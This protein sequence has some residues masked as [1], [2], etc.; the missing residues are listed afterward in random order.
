MKPLVAI[1][2]LQLVGIAHASGQFANVPADARNGALGGMHAPDTAIRRV[3]IGYRQGYGMAD[4]ATR[5]VAATWNLGSRGRMATEY[6]HF[7]DRIY[8]EQQA[9]AGYSMRLTDWLTAGIR[10]RYLRMATDDAHYEARQWLAAE[11][12]V[13]A[14][15]G[16]RLTLYA[17]GGSRP[18]DETRPWQ[19]RIG[20]AYR[21]VEGLTTLVDL[22]SEERTRLRMGAE[23]C[24]RRHYFIRAGL[25]THPTL[26]TFGLGARLGI[27][28]I[29]FAVESHEYLGL[30][31]Q[32]TLSVCP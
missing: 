16:E 11:A 32:I 19:G 10:G 27:Y 13:H 6:I 25:A 24:Y 22:D 20:L 28:G 9:A 12:A 4:M 1:L 21:A 26:L 17:E 29:D 5:M 7:G 18:W 2:L 14:R 15:L 30:T 31:P 3:G 23:Y 8:H